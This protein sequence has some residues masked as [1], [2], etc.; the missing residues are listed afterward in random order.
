MTLKKLGI[1][2]WSLAFLSAGDALCAASRLQVCASK[3]KSAF[4]K[5]MAEEVEFEFEMSGKYLLPPCKKLAS[6]LPKNEFR[7]VFLDLDQSVQVDLDCLGGE[8]C[9]S[10]AYDQAMKGAALVAK[11]VND[12]KAAMRHSKPIAEVPAQP[13]D[14]EWDRVVVPL[15]KDVKMPVLT[16]RISSEPLAVHAQPQKQANGSAAL[17]FGGENWNYTFDRDQSKERV[18]AV[19]SRIYPRMALSGA[20][21]FTPYLLLSG[22]FGA[23]L[24]SL[25]IKANQ[26]IEGDGLG[27]L[28]QMYQA[29]VL[30]GVFKSFGSF[31]EIG[32]DAGYDFQGAFVDEQRLMQHAVTVVPSFQSHAIRVGPRVILAR[33]SGKGM[34][35]IGAGFYPYTHYIESPDEPADAKSLFNWSLNGSVRLMLGTDL[36]AD[37]TLRAHI[38]YVRYTGSALRETADGEKWGAGQVTNVSTSAMAGLGWLF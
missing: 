30:L 36:Y 3:C 23:S 17:C 15:A 8:T 22:S 2:V 38:H 28:S 4:C 20:Y 24:A 35:D 32:L 25:R 7:L 37:A 33:S 5:K 14:E 26:P 9:M 34:I 6:S 27:V 1:L 10:Q 29:T 12:V 13:K 11:V 18:G 16:E 21:W 19:H 31:F